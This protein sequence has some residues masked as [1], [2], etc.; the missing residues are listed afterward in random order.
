MKP[1]TDHGR[2]C[3]TCLAEGLLGRRAQAVVAAGVLAV[4]SV[5]PPAAF[6]QQA[7]EDP[8]VTV[9]FDPGGDDGE[10]SQEVTDAPDPE[11]VSDA[12]AAEP[13]TIAEPGSG[14]EAPVAEA[15]E[16]AA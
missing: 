8:A 7:M 16:G 12:V 9:D 4:A 11:P 10:V 2:L 13:V 6:A 1:F 5:A 15:P 14:G 3:R